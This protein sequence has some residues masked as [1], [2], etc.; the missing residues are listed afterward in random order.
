[1][2]F[3]VVVDLRV[4]EHPM[5]QFTPVVNLVFDKV[6]AGDSMDANG[7]ELW[8]VLLT[9][10]SEY[11]A[12]RTFGVLF[13]LR[14]VSRVFWKLFFSA[15][16]PNI[17][18]PPALSTADL[19]S[20]IWN[21]S[22][23][24]GKSNPGLD[25]SFSIWWYYLIA[26]QYKS[27]LSFDLLGLIGIYQRD[28]VFAL[29]LLTE[30][31]DFHFYQDIRVVESPLL[32]K[33]L[34]KNCLRYMRTAAFNTLAPA[35]Q[36]KIQLWLN[37][38]ISWQEPMICKTVADRVLC[39]QLHITIMSVGKLLMDSRFRL[40]ED[41]L[42]YI[43]KEDLFAFLTGPTAATFDR[44]DFFITCRHA[45]MHLPD[46]VSRLDDLFALTERPMPLSFTHLLLEKAE[47]ITAA[48]LEVEPIWTVVMCEHALHIW[49]WKSRNLT[50]LVLF[51]LHSLQQNTDDPGLHLTAPS[52][53]DLIRELKERLPE[54][55]ELRLSAPSRTRCFEFATII[56][57]E[58]LDENLPLAEQEPK[59][60]KL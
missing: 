1:M 28:D 48:R 18:V 42:D 32:R 31:P 15:K 55:L 21:L 44:D 22:R 8:C 19:E 10:L 38:A 58:C 35:C 4:H 51:A 12:Y 36:G 37:A 39:Q 5:S 9:N 14:R 49:R 27:A 23:F 17:P 41:L 50:I 46:A 47:L 20:S 29:R 26:C 3:P 56:A 59:R 53:H 2:S 30:C 40:G 6:L 16:G 34:P 52:R 24:V 13:A 60:Q 7:M 54:C 57:N 33:T 25:N 43:P 45:L 11:S